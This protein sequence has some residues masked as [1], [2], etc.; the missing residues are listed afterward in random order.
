MIYNQLRSVKRKAQ[1]ST[2]K[3][4]PI[5]NSPAQPIIYP[6]TPKVNQTVTGQRIL[7][8]ISS[9]GKVVKSLTQN[10]SGQ[11]DAFHTVIPTNTPI[12]SR[13]G[14]KVI[15]RQIPQAKPLKSTDVSR[16]SPV[17]AQQPKTPVMFQYQPVSKP[18]Q[19][20][21]ISPVGIPNQKRIFLTNTAA[22]VFRATV[23]TT[24]A[25]EKTVTPAVAPP[26]TIPADTVESFMLPDLTPKLEGTVLAQRSS[27]M[28]IQRRIM[29]KRAAEA[30]RGP[31]EKV[32]IMEER[33]PLELPMN[34]DVGQDLM[35]AVK[36][37]VEAEEDTEFQGE[38]A[39]HAIHLVEAEE[40]EKEL[41]PPQEDKKKESGEQAQDVDA[42]SSTSTISCV[43]ESNTAEVSNTA[44][45][46]VTPPTEAS[47]PPKEQSQSKDANVAETIE[48]TPKVG[49]SQT[50]MEYSKKPSVRFL[51]SKGFIGQRSQEG[52]SINMEVV[53]DPKRLFN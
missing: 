6:N 26:T 21:R 45:K 8:T 42:D 46:V 52:V 44:A 16:A 7:Y 35:Q 50:V 25:P 47:P 3:P 4:K 41:D 28:V 15:Y 31:P 43:T 20:V 37:E 14:P 49:S 29:E 34:D 22:K 5:V 23:A 24:V 27:P 51:Q 53:S 33:D 17:M 48:N 1:Y 11:V 2:I 10:S 19:T 40:D 18:Q 12:N 39:E 38:I 9:A 32:Q 13:G 36:G 30:L